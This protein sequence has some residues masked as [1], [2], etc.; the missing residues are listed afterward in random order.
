MRLEEVEKQAPDRPTQPAEEPQPAEDDHPS[1][2]DPDPA[3]GSPEPDR[4]PTPDD[5]VQ[6]RITR[7]PGDRATPVLLGRRG[8]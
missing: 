5:S 8:F 7:I 3:E 4:P 2:S 1:P 6:V